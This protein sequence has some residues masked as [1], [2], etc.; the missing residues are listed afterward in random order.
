MKL[1]WLWVEKTY[2]IVISPTKDIKINFDKSGSTQ[3][4]E[5]RQRLV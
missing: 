2:S 1:K 5:I 3:N 4:F